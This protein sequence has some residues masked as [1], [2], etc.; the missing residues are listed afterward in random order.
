MAVAMY[1]VLTQTGCAAY[2]GASTV[3]LITTGKGIP[4]HS[5]SQITDA[6]CGVVNWLKGKHYY[7]EIKRDAGTRY[8]TSLD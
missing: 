2:L 5:A 1:L 3:S 7:C 8:V 4:E 6:E